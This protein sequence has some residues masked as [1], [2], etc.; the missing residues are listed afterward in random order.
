S[1]TV[2]LT[3]FLWSVCSQYWALYL[4][5]QCTEIDCNTLRLIPTTG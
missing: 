3:R 1:I 2:D 5:P 4:A